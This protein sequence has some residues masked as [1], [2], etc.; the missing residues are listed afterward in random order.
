M[1]MLA[2]AS[3]IRLAFM[4]LI[5]LSHLPLQIAMMPVK[6]MMILS[7]GIVFVIPC[8]LYF[9]SLLL[10]IAGLALDDGDIAWLPSAC[11]CWVFIVFE[12]IGLKAV[13]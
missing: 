3:V 7:S 9:L 12:F 2:D 10:L 8:C 11:Y 5:C 1:V 13:K 4:P 6:K